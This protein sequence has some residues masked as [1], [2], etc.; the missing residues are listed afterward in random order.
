VV[1]G[2]SGGGKSSVQS[3]LLR[4]YDPVRGKVTYDGQGTHCAR[5]GSVA[6][7]RA[8]PDIREFNP[9]SWRNI[10]GIVPQVSTLTKSKNMPVPFLLF[11]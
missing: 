9:S 4:Y 1:S 11:E 5:R 2:K 10:I 6:V 3:L 7:E 8:F